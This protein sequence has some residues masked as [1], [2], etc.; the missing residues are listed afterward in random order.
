MER[1]YGEEESESPQRGR[2]SDCVRGSREKER[3]RERQGRVCRAL[4]L[5]VLNACMRAIVCVCVCVC[6]CLFLSIYG[7]LRV[8]VCLF[9]PSAFDRH[10][11]CVYMC[12]CVCVCVS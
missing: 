6:V 8:S 3:Q 5:F 2:K 12:V 10:T 7:E 1:E 11:V 9:T 4:G